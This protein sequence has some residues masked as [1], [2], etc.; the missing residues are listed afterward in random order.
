MVGGVGLGSN[1]TGSLFLLSF[2]T[3]SCINVPSFTAYPSGHFQ[4][5]KNLL[6]TIF[7]SCAVRSVQ[8]TPHCHA[9]VDSYLIKLVRLGGGKPENSNPSAHI[10]IHTISM[11]MAEK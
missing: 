6:E 5:L 11:K 1:T 2:S 10:V 4:R 7:T 9:A 3:F 8:R